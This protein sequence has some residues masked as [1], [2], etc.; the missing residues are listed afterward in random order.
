MWLWRGLEK[1]YIVTAIAVTIEDGDIVGP[2]FKTIV[3]T[4]VTS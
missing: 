1:F 3:D 4:F 2:Q